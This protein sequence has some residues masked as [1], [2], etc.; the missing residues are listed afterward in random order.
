MSEQVFDLSVFLAVAGESGKIC[1]NLVVKRNFAVVEKDHDGGGCGDGL[2]DRSDVKD[3]VC[4]G[5][6]L[7][8][9]DYFTAKRLEIMNLIRPTATQEKG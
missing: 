9:L 2:G 5:G 3:G 7:K 4:L 8:R 1:G 6:F